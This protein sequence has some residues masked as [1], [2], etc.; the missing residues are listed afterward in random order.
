MDKIVSSLTLDH[1]QPGERAVVTQ[2]ASTGLNR[3]RMMDLGIL[4]GTQ[5]EIEMKSPLGDPVAYRVRGAVIALRR[6]QA[7]EIFIAPET[8]NGDI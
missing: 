6:E 8:E 4:P 3:R 2:L 7:R 1:L 5:I